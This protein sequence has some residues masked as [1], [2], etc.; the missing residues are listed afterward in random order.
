[1]L[2]G[3]QKSQILS[4]PTA[5]LESTESKNKEYIEYAFYQYVSLYDYVGD[6]SV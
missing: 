3:L 4:V 6:L 2:Y 5:H 1:M